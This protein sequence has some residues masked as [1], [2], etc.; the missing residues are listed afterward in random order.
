MGMKKFLNLIVLGALFAT[1]LP[2]V[3]NA[4]TGFFIDVADFHPNIQ[5]IRSLKDAEIVVGYGDGTFGGNKNINRAEFLKI[6]MEAADIEAKGDGCFKD[7]KDQWFAPYICAAKT[8]GFVDGYKDGY[9]RPEQEINFAEASKIITNVMKLEG[10][11]VTGGNWFDAYVGVLDTQDVIPVTINS[12]EEKLTRN[13]MAE[14]IWRIRE[15]VTYKLSNSYENI[16][17]GKEMQELGA[18]LANFE[19]CTELKTYFE[20][21]A[22]NPLYSGLGGGVEEDFDDESEEDAVS[23]SVKSTAAP[24]AGEGEYSETNVQ[25]EGVD[26]ADIVKNDGKYIYWLKDNTVRVI[27]AY[28]ASSMKELSKVT[29]DDENFYPSEMFLDNDRLMVI[30]TSYESIL[31]Q[32]SKIDSSV[33]DIWQPYNTLTKVYIFNT[34][35]K[36]DVKVE[37]KLSL[38][39]SYLSSRKV[40]DKVYLI[41]NDYNYYWPWGEGDTY[42]EGDILP[43]FSDSRTGKVDTLV[44]CSD[45]QFVPGVVDNTSYMSVLSVDIDSP[46][47]EVKKEVVIGSSSNIYASTKNLY[48]AQP[49]YD[50]WAWYKEGGETEQTY[51]HKFSLSDLSYKGVG[52]VSGS[53]LNQF[54]MDEDGEYFRIATTTGDV[55]S[56]TQSKNNLFVLNTDLKVVGSLTGLAPGE[57]IYSVRFIGDRAYMVTYE[58]T[59]PLFVIGLENP[60]VP[61]VLGQLKIPGFSNYLHPYGENYLIGFGKETT[62]DGVDNGF[63]WVEGMKI[64]MFDV[65]DVNNPKELHRELIGD[66]GTYSELLYNHKALLFNEEKGFMAFPITVAKLSDEEKAGTSWIW[67]KYIFQGAYVYD[68]SV[69]DGFKL[70]GT[71]THYDAGYD[72]ENYWSGISEDIQRILYIG[73]H[74]YTLSNQAVKANVMSDLKEAKRVDF[75]K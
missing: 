33:I 30:G 32:A 7:V 10:P 51:I 29:F 63:S 44:E 39:G 6:V 5:A 9:F 22:D 48:I 36:S 74:F 49:K 69:A 60:S 21:N 72:S 73:N 47:S 50:Y 24:G 8:L 71:V 45:V 3:S 15:G 41:A 57:R 66:R 70:R 25:V 19:S 75:V 38:E 52:T 26:E 58:E 4:G 11:V 13:Q 56:S 35:N 64:A 20:M 16:K 28:P 34:A 12:F 67:G 18:K 54:S 62:D 23:E 46:T 61:V 14:M 42:K 55:W 43:L 17:A 2:Q 37:R 27:E 68:I 59:D 31:T 65:T 1:I 53:I 40:G